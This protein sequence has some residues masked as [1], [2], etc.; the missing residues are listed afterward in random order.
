MSVLLSHLDAEADRGYLR[1]KARPVTVTPGASP[2]W[3]V[4]WTDG[5][6]VL[7]EG[8]STFGDTSTTKE[9]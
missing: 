1:G 8:G 7:P 9:S 4:T 2:E 6:H 5:T 3:Q